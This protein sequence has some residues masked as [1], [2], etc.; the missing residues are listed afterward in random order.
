MGIFDLFRR[1]P[2]IPRCPITPDDRRWIENSFA[3][4]GEQLGGDIV[5]QR[6]VIL[7]TGEFFPKEYVPDWDGIE[8]LMV[9]V[10]QWMDIDRGSVLLD[11]YAE[12]EVPQFGFG[13]HR[14][15]GTAGQLEWDEATRRW[16]VAVNQNMLGDPTAVV[17][18][19]AHESA[20]IHLF[21]AGRVDPEVEEDNEPLTDLLAIYYGFGVFVGNSAFRSDQTDH[22]TTATWSA[23]RLGYL[24]EPMIAY[25]L[26]L[27]ALAKQQTNPDWI[28]HLAY[29]IRK[30]FE[31]SL[32]YLHYQKAKGLDSLIGP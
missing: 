7:P 18:V 5:R 24:P 29:G 9:R 20:H 11:I 21:G 10:C 30:P 2:Q 26:A 14:S 28:D 32:A 27:T 16:V 4:F 8:E 12:D 23:K 17:A 3:W 19:M 31:N 15:D 6:P 13:T 1:E 25:A 22:G